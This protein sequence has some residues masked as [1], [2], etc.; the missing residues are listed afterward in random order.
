ML[1]SFNSARRLALAAILASVP[2]GPLMA[3]LTQPE[4]PVILTVSGAIA[5]TNGDG[6]ATFD[7]AMLEAMDPQSFETGTIWTEGTSTF[8][9]VPLRRILEA[10]GAEGEVLTLRALNDYSVEMPSE[11]VDDN[12]PL[13]AY[14]RDGAPLSRRDRGPLWVIYPYDSDAA[15]RND[16]IYTRSVWQLDRIEVGG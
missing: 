16:T 7:L 8:T 13:I 10:V 1:L 2:V 15:Y 3:D 5:Q 4:G 14:A 12:A 9:G 6:A 11:A